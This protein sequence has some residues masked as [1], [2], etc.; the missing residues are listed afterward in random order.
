[1]EPIRARITGAGLALVGDTITKASTPPDARTAGA[2]AYMNKEIDALQG[3][4]FSPDQ[5]KFNIIKDWMESGAY[6][7]TKLNNQNFNPGNITWSKHSTVAQKGRPYGSGYFAKYNN[8]NE[9]ATDLKRVLS[10]SPGRPINA[11]GYPDLKDFVN[12]LATNK[13]MGSDSPTAYLK[14]MQGAQQ[15]IRI[16]QS[17]ETDAAQNIAMPSPSWDKVKD[18]F[19]NL[20]TGVKIGAA[21]VGTLLIVKLIKE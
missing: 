4:G 17:L 5:V 15:R 14:A 13:Y 1:M 20:P 10:L 16:L 2:L 18:F 3:A 6:D 21:A 7:P 19:T 9:Y 12:R 8:L 11:T